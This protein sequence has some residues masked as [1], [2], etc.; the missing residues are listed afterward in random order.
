MTKR[1][2]PFAIVG[3]VLVLAIGAGTLLYRHRL[4][5]VPVAPQ[6]LAAGKVGA[7]PPH[8]R[9]ST[10]GPVSIEEFGDYEC[11]PCSAVFSALK[12]V[13]GDY[14]GRLSLTFRQ[15]PLKMHKHAM[16]AARAA[17]AAGLQGRFWEMHD[18]LYGNRF[19]W[20]RAPDVRALFDGY[21]S[22]AGVDLG[23]FK[24][25]VEGAEVARRISDDQERAASIG[26][27]RTPVVFVNGQRLEFSSVTV[28][29]LHAAIDKALKGRSD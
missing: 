6:N 24:Q 1:Y 22:A 17:E 27:D 10:R 20:T 29:G 28:E 23:R 9:G 26:V 2:L 5:Q 8:V 18:A 14:G 25:D 15:Y 7:E 12:Q 16:D 3:A 11:L 4:A 13:E 19:V 21:A